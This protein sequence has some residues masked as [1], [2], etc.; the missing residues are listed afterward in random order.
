M[1]TGSGG[2]LG[3]VPL[4]TVMSRIEGFWLSAG[5]SLG[6]GLTSTEARK[7][8]EA[9]ERMLLPANF[10]THVATLA[11]EGRLVVVGRFGKHKVYASPNAPADA[12]VRGTYPNDVVREALIASVQA[13]GGPAPTSV[14]LAAVHARAPEIEKT[15]ATNQLWKFERGGPISVDGCLYRV[16]AQRL[17]LPGGATRWEWS[18]WS[19]DA[20]DTEP[21]EPS[22]TTLSYRQA[23]IFTVEAARAVLGA[24]PTRL[25]W[26]L[27]VEQA[28]AYD[29]IAA[30]VGARTG[31]GTFRA[32]LESNRSDTDRAARRYT[33]LLRFESHFAALHLVDP[34]FGLSGDCSPCGDLGDPTARAT[35]GGERSI[36]DGVLLL[37]GL[38]ATRVHREMLALSAFDAWWLDEGCHLGA[39]D[40]VTESCIRELIATRYA[41][42]VTTMTKILPP[43]RWAAALDAAEAHVAVLQRWLAS[44]PRILNLK[45][46]YLAECVTE[47]LQALAAVRAFLPRLLGT[48]ASV[49]PVV[50]VDGPPATCSAMCAPYQG[51]VSSSRLKEFYE[52][53]F[54]GDL[55]RP[56]FS[57]VF[58]HAR[59]SVNTSHMPPTPGAGRRLDTHRDRLDAWRI[60]VSDAGA[61]TA[62]VLLSDADRLVG[63]LLRDA[64]VL[65]RLLA[66]LPAAAH[67]LRRTFQ[68]ARGL[69]GCPPTDVEVAAAAS[70]A[71]GRAVLLASL[72]ADPSRIA[73]RLPAIR[74]IWASA[75]AS[76][77]VPL[78][79]LAQ[80][81]M[82]R[83]RCDEA[84]HLVE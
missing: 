1:T 27:Y 28:L 83:V 54:A 82:L 22:R 31:Y 5:V 60:V 46:R 58:R 37:E 40:S 71:D 19:I 78:T 67:E 39:P 52:A 50:G 7:R 13:A 8:W 53:R 51:G 59:K 84:L 17:T 79:A 76:I 32:A 2:G 38:A 30:I 61:H 75:E 81:A 12:Q 80:R 63:G 72:L 45:A 42:V 29:P 64:E 23:V 56:S 3:R 6:R 55:R 77:S 34:R 35:D 33:G 57:W 49:L 36:P 26:Q 15:C 66:R 20:N 21:C 14:I 11:Q 47:P 18:L 62:W 68:I 65:A 48:A 69:L 70:V 4:G 43:H 44:S 74:R 9:F 24:P 73:M 10:S 25:E 41:L 16:V